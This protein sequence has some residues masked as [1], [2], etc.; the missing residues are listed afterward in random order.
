MYIWV[1]GNL[2]NSW[3][4]HFPHS[5]VQMKNFGWEKPQVPKLRWY[6][7]LGFFDAHKNIQVQL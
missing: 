1:G 5:I 3:S 2:E 7:Y 4:N 6:Q